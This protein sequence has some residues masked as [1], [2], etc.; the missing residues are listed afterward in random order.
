MTCIIVDDE[1]LAR[2]GMAALICNSEGLELIGSFSN[3]AAASGFLH[4]GGVDLI[5]LDIEMP[6]VNGIDFARSISSSALVIFTTAYPGYALDSY[7]V[8]AIDYIVKP[9]KAERFHK[10]VQKATTYLSL[11]QS[12]ACITTVAPAREDYFFIRAD[13]KILKIHMKDIAFIEGMKDYVI[14][15]VENRK[16]LTAMNIKTIYEQLPRQLFVRISKSFIVNVD[17]IVSLDSESVMIGHDEI[18]IGDAY[19][20]YFFDE[21]I[22]KK[23]FG[24]NKLK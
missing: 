22:A 18:P 5:F 15:H 9:V 19:R 17:Q 20:N 14:L 3:A 6:A 1:P 10:A 12:G 13:R 8:D 7:E 21:F 23:M 11:Q 16:I 24:R 4:M 2:E